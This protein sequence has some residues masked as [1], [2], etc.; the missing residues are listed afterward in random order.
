M[1]FIVNL[2]VE[3][4]KFSMYHKLLDKLPEFK[5][6]QREIKINSILEGKK[7]QFDISEIVGYRPISC[8][9]TQGVGYQIGSMSFIIKDDII[10]KLL[11]DV[12]FT[13]SN[14]S[15]VV[16]YVSDGYISSFIID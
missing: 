8:F 6:F 4:N 9:D 14:V 11:I 10:E 15:K 13:K 16:P 12:S 1:E 5:Q 3:N 7:I 2:N